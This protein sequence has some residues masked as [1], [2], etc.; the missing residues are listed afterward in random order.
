M[1]RAEHE[2][3]SASAPPAPSV[4]EVSS[5]A[6]SPPH[7]A[8]ED[9]LGPS[10]V[11]TDWWRVE[12]GPFGPGMYGSGGFGP[13]E[14]VPGFV[15]GIELPELLKPPPRPDDRAAALERVERIERAERAELAA[16]AGGEDALDDAD[17]DESGARRRWRP[18]LR[19]TGRTGE[20][21]GVGVA[22]SV[23]VLVLLAAALLVGGAIFG[24]WI[25]LGA[26]WLLAY[27]SR[28]LSRAE[29]KWAAMGVP[30]LVAAGTIVWLW[31]RVNE[32]W[33][34]PIPRGGLGHALTDALPV[35]VRIAAV[36]SALFLIWRSRRRV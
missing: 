17:E 31:G 23:G 11:G 9:E 18:R 26:G 6:A 1:P 3:S 27:G 34:E 28:R 30:G 2:S 36:A 20:D 16:R 12:S 10:D 29:A 5:T 25:A 32:G 33:G 19:R 7:L 4:P 35:V 8:G 13:G 24:S 21:G 22:G 14:S 15:G